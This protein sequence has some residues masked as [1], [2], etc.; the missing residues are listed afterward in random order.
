[1]DESAYKML[2]NVGLEWPSLSFDFVIDELGTGR[3]RFPHSLTCVVGSQAEDG[4]RNSLKLVKMESLGRVA[5][6]NDFEEGMSDDENESDEVRN[7]LFKDDV[8]QYIPLK[9]LV[10]QY[11]RISALKRTLCYNF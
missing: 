3:T 2:H 10:F 9:I 7:L 4:E 6:T 1:M 8:V 5:R 11:F